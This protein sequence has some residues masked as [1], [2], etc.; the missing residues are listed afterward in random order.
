MCCLVS[1]R[2]FQEFPCQKLGGFDA[3]ELASTREEMASERELRD[4]WHQRSSNLSTQA[5]LRGRSRGIPSNWSKKYICESYICIYIYIDC[6]FSL[7][8][9]WYE[10]KSL[11]CKYIVIILTFCATDLPRALRKLGDFHSMEVLLGCYFW[12]WFFHRASYI[13]HFL[14]DLVFFL[15]QLCTEWHVVV[16]FQLIILGSFGIHI[17]IVFISWCCVLFCEA[18]GLLSTWCFFC[19]FFQ[20]IFWL[21]PLKASVASYSAVSPQH[22]CEVTELIEQRKQMREQKCQ[23]IQRH[24]GRRFFFSWPEKKSGWWQPFDIS[25]IHQLRER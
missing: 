2:N 21:F 7:R 14:H 15:I 6:F 1:P 23:D 18:R 25:K 9:T 5:K 22:I 10:W 12:P 13:P 16:F 4:W 20:V 17:M 11:I 24:F 3:G 8:S 19:M